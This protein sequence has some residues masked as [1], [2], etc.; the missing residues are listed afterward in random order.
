MFLAS[1]GG[2]CVQDGINLRFLSTVIPRPAVLKLIIESTPINSEEIMSIDI[3]GTMHSLASF[4]GRFNASPEHLAQTELN[5]ACLRT[6]VKL[7]DR[8]Q[9]RPPEEAAAGD[10]SAH[11]VSRLC[12]KYSSLLVRG[13]IECQL[14]D[15]RSDNVSEAMSIHKKNR[16]AQREAELRELVITGLTHM[17][18]ANSEHGFKQS[19]LPVSSLK[20]PE[21][22][23]EAVPA[24]VNRHSRLLELMKGLNMV[25]VMA[26]CETCPQSEVEIMV[27]VMLNLFDTRS[28]LMALLKYMIER[29]VAATENEAQ[30]F[31]SNT[32]CTRFLS[33]FAK[34]HGY[35]YLRSL[36]IPL[37]KAMAAV[38]PGHGYELDPG[39]PDVGETK[40]A[41][42]LENVKV[43]ASTFLEII[44]MSL[45]TLLRQMSR[46][47]CTPISKVVQN[48][49]PDCKFSPMGAFI[50]LRFISPAIV[51]P[52]T[53]DV[54]IPKDLTPG[55]AVVDSSRT[56]DHHQDH[57]EFSE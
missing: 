20:A 21:F 17:V 6:C 22:E 29:E 18:S 7:L 49:W 9:I 56:Y 33:A 10:D 13:H 36:I 48:V 30:L 50:F 28:T 23:I 40:A 55:R 38:P 52:E 16:V 32:T 45:P 39:K 14:D 19:S 8:L 15:V 34:V 11:S 43:I 44:S 51:A 53:I 47:I 1:L 3:S 46:E 31:R 54:E 41:Q 57:P 5:F 35:T 25:L 37:I 24:A 12:P 4:I 27:S 2:A 42:N 26:I